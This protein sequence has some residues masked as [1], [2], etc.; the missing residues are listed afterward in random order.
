MSLRKRLRHLSGVQSHRPLLAGVAVALSLALLFPE[1]VR[2]FGEGSAFEA[3]VLL[4]GT[5]TS[6]ARPSAPARWAWEL[7]QRTAAPSVMKPTSVRADSATIADSPFLYWSSDRAIE[8]LSR[9]EIAGLRRFF[10]LGGTLFVDDASVDSTGDRP[11]PFGASARIEL[12]KV[13]PDQLPMR[14]NTDHVVFRS[15][16]FLRR[17]EGRVAG[18]KHLEA[19]VRGGNVSVLFSQHDVGGALARNPMGSY[20]YPVTPGGDAQREKAIRLAVNIA[21][22]ALCSNYKDDQVHA[23]FLMRRRALSGP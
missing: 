13:L 6:A 17:A 21:M 19:I 8:P 9:A 5:T 23:P 15:F 12:A 4:T 18:P 10:S 7:V 22:Y 20:E 11:G 1:P 3:R 2:A 16:Y 14:L